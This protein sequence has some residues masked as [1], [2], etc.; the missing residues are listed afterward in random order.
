MN[1]KTVYEQVQ[2]E[3]DTA[4]LETALTRIESIPGQGTVDLVV[5]EWR[6]HGGN[7]PAARVPTG[8][9]EQRPYC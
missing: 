7:R 3:I 1:V 2:Y 6:F 8:Y 5:A 4:L 9:S